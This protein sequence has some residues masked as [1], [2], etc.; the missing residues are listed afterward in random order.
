MIAVT[1]NFRGCNK[2]W[3]ERRAWA[4]RSSRKQKAEYSHIY[5]DPEEVHGRPSKK[6]VC[7]VDGVYLVNI[8]RKA[9]GEMCVHWRYSGK[10]CGLDDWGIMVRCPVGTADF[11]SMRS[12]RLW[13]PPRLLFRGHPSPFHREKTG[14]GLKMTSN[15]HLVPKERTSEP[16]TGIPLTACIACTRTVVVWQLGWGQFSTMLVYWFSA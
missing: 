15:L 8:D 4:Y 16:N 7:A 1:V 13:N 12:Y 3:L 14:W 2:Y 9:H 5:D 6:L 10:D 11:S